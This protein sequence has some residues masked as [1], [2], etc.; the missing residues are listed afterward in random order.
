MSSYQYWQLPDR[1]ARTG[2]DTLTLKT[3]NSIPKPGK[4]EVLIKVHAV[5]LNFRDLII[6]KNQ[7]PLAIQE[8]PLVPASD[9][10]GEVVEVGQ[11]VDQFKKS[12]HVA[13]NFAIKH[14]KGSFPTEKEGATALGGA[15]D[16]MMTQYK[17][18]PEECLVKLPDHLSFE[19]A[20]TLPCAALTA[21]NALHGLAS[22]PVLP[23]STV[24]A[25]GTGG[26]SVFCAQLGIASGAKV[27]ISSSS[28][29]KL[30]KVKALFTKE[31]AQRLYT[32][33]YNT[34][35]DWDKEVLKVSGGKG[36]THILEVGGAGTLEKSHACIKRGGVISNIGFIGGGKEMPNVPLMNLMTST[37]F[38]GILVGSVEQFGDMNECI[39]THKIKPMVDRVFEF[40]DAPAAYTYQWSQKH[41]GKVV[42]KLQ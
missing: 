3:A 8:E 22:N 17:V 15:L 27:V 36:A 19:E 5:S 10:A 32:V 33:N 30:E 21:W 42:I 23:G 37:I 39:D 4:G 41:V 26:V 7:Y 40:K 34:T 13:A 18:L 1:N 11:G 14:L 28:D 2:E 31:Q 25:I 29:E 6:T 16:G 9:G 20:A 38:R 35:P 12:D 24:V